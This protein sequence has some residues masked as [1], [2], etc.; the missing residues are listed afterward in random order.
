MA[1]Y[2]KSLQEL[3]FLPLSFSGGPQAFVC[4]ILDE[5]TLSVVEFSVPGMGQEREEWACP[6]CKGQG[7]AVEGWDLAVKGGT[8]M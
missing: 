4:L 5:S 7:L 3:V 6:G 8:W 1:W 2:S